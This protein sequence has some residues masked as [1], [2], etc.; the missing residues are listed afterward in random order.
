M[1]LDIEGTTT[2]MAFVHGTLY[3]Y[4]RDHLGAFV[5]DPA[6]AELIATLAPQFAAE[7]HGEPASGFPPEWRAEPRTALLDSIE[8]YAMWLM[9]RD[10][11]STP[12]KTLQGR[13]WAIGYRAGLLRGAVFPD[14]A[15]ALRR[16][17]AA[18]LVLAVYSSGS[19]EAQR[20]IFSMTD[21]GDL[22]PLITYF[23][24]TMV[25]PKRSADSYP[26]IAS[27][28]GIDAAH[29]LFLSDVAAELEA[30]LASGWQVI[31]T[32]RPDHF[33]PNPGG[34]EQVTTFDALQ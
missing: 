32:V 13:I 28:M 16:W 22:T 20:L 21:E 30:A 17:H 19:V 11:K 2:P 8:A 1:V 23:F 31:L 27:E 4:A 18:G 24:D 3:S 6:H 14:V 10:R 34:F 15:P 25:G 33:A 26:R 12:L 9:D 5:R 7:H 29:I